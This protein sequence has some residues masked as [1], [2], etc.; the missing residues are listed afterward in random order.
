LIFEKLGKPAEE[1]MKFITN[2]N[3]KKFID[4]LP[5]KSTVS[6]A[7]FI[8]YENKHALDLLDQML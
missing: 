1:N 2:L 6:S 7:T 3:A 5:N 4:S 8:K